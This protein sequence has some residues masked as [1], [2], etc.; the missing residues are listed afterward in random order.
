MMNRRRYLLQL[1]ACASAW[2][3]AAC[4]AY[5]QVQGYPSRPLRMIVPFAP[6][7]QNDAVARL[8]AQKLTEVLGKQCVVEN[9]AG[10][11]GGIGAGRAAQAA[12]DGYTILVHDTGFVIAP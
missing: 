7:G 2:P 10:G 9:I 4:L 5:A 11:G 8:V 3:A 12:R 6:G 1:A